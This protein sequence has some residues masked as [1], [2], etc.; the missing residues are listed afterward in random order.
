MGTLQVIGIALIIAVSFVNLQA[1]PWSKSVDTDFTMTQNSYS[2][3]WAGGEAGNI[4]WVW[5][6]NGVFEK[7]VSPKFKF[8][9]TTRLSFGQTHI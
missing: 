6:G 9:N 1:D 2:D 3:S 8:K 4:S 5:N 7:Q